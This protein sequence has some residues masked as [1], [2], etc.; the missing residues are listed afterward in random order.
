MLDP[1]LLLSIVVWASV[2]YVWFTRRRHK[3]PLPP[4]PKRVPIF[5]NAFDIPDN[6][7]RVTYNDWSRQYRM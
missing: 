1:T 4:G 2:I 6:E 5:G 3:L 7:E